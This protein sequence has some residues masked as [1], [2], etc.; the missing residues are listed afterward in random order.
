MN[1]I[2]FTHIDS[3]PTVCLVKYL[4]SPPRCDPTTHKDGLASPFLVTERG[5]IPIAWG[6]TCLWK[7]NLRMVMRFYRIQN[8]H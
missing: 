8:S 2:E 7:K 4:M 5:D 1:N 3:D 6:L